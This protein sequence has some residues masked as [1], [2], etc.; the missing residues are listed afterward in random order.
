M[1]SSEV[2]CNRVYKSR[3]EC[4][5]VQCSTVECLAGISSVAR[6]LLEPAAELQSTD[7]S[8]L[9]WYTGAC[10]ILHHDLHDELTAHHNML[11]NKRKW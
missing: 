6:W 11:Y 1:Q 3:V 9:D 5:R 8:R 2:E 4:N 10:F 7:R